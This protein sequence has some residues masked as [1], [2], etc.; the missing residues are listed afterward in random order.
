MTC[1]SSS[2]KVVVNCK[3][4]CFSRMITPVSRLV[5]RSKLVALCDRK[6]DTTTRSTSF[7]KKLRFEIGRY[8]VT[9]HTSTSSVGFLSRGRT[10]AFLQKQQTDHSSVT[11][12][13]YSWAIEQWYWLFSSRAKF[14]ANTG[15]RKH[16]LYVAFQ[17]SYRQQIAYILIF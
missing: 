11:H 12:C 9:S 10:T 16:L 13:T 4:S 6:R 1:V 15:S 14:S 7:D 3:H 17:S 2:Y 5:G 8:E